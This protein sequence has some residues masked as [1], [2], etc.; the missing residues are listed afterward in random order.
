[1]SSRLAAPMATTSGASSPGA[2]ARS[3]PAA[4]EKSHW[5]VGAEARGARRAI[6]IA[7]Q[8]GQVVREQRE[9]DFPASGSPPEAVLLALADGVHQLRDR[10]ADAITIVVVDKTLIGYLRR[11]WRPRSLRMHAALKL[12]V[13]AARGLTVAFESGSK[14]KGKRS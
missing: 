6:V 7:R 12:F 5:R 9:L 4:A 1:M 10:G 8:V 13:E 11:G 3:A 14:A 2:P